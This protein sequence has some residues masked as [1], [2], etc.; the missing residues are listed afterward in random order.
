[1][2]SNVKLLAKQ[3]GAAG[4]LKPAT[5]FPFAGRTH[6]YFSG[7]LIYRSPAA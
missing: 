5:P 1:M 4:Y 6:D 7:S 3:N 2:Q